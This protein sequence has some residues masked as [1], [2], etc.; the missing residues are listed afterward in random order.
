M[1]GDLNTPGKCFDIIMENAMESDFLLALMRQ[2]CTVGN[3]I[4]LIE[5]ETPM[6]AMNDMPVIST[7][8]PLVPLAMPTPCTSYCTT[9]WTTSLLFTQRDSHPNELLN[10]GT[11]FVSRHS[12]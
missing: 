11:R 2:S 4:A 12:L 7:I 6:K 3:I 8:T 1:F 10:Y 9:A 5:P